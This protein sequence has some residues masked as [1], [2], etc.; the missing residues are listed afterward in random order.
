MTQ[1]ARLI[2]DKAFN[3]KKAANEL[4]SEEKFK[5]ADELLETLCPE[6]SGFGEI[7]KAFMPSNPNLIDEPYK[8]CSC[9]HGSGLAE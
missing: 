6:C 9:C 7:P 3:L 4:D 1:Q 8:V 2:F 5:E